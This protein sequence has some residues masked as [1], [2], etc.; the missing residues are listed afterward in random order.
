MAGG[1]GISRLLG[2]VGFP[3]MKPS[4]SV[5]RHLRYLCGR[6]FITQHFSLD[7]NHSE[8]LMDEANQVAETVS[9]SRLSISLGKFSMADFFDNNT[10]THDPRTDFLNWGLMSNGA[11][12]YAA[13]TRGYTY[14]LVADY[15]H[16]DWSVRFGTSL[17]PEYANGPTLNFNYSKSNSETL[18][19]E[20]RYSLGQRKGTMR[21]LGYFNV[22]KAPN[23]DSV[24]AAKLNGT[25]TSMDVIYGKEYGGKKWGFG[26]NADQELSSSLSAF[27]RA[28]WND[29]KTAT[30]AFAEIDNSVSAGLRR[31]W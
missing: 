19:L 22:S 17:M 26:V 20:R 2:I 23:Y 15:T 1:K 31:V 3:P 29:G 30:W 4:G 10:V 12:D 24:V 6:F 16:A 28:G 14:G 21:L 7:H 25:D 5:I 27:L 8:K 18:E 13:N 11:Y 9:T